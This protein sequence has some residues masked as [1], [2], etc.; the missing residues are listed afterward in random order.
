MLLYLS[1]FSSAFI[2][3]TLLP[4][5]SE[6]HLGLLLH[7][8]LNPLLLWLA[9]TTGNTLGACV[10]YWLGTQLLRFQGKPWFPVKPRQLDK[11]HRQFQRYGVWSLLLAWL[12]VVGDPLTFI[13]GILRCN[14]WLFVALVGLGKGL[15]YGL[16]LWWVI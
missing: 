15:R 5:V 6:V 14:P 3:A 1:L 4:A 8:G 12:P 13:A 11:A 10:N 7:Q 16:V 2:A 9:A